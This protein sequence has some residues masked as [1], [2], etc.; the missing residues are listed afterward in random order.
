MPPVLCDQPVESRSGLL[1]SWSVNET[2]RVLEADVIQLG[3]GRHCDLHVSGSKGSANYGAGRR[4]TKHE[5]EEIRAAAVVDGAVARDQLSGAAVRETPG[6]VAPGHGRCVPVPGEGYPPPL[7]LE[8]GGRP[9][10]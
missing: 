10:G 9:Y 3:R 6:P 8:S 2:Q 5:R 1:A 4:P 7:A